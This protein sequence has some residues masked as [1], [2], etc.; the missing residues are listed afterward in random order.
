MAVLTNVSGM[1]I[2][3]KFLWRG[4]FRYINEAY[5]PVVEQDDWD[6]ATVADDLQAQILAST[7]PEE[8]MHVD[9]RFMS[10]TARARGMHPQV[11]QSFTRSLNID[12]V[13][14]GNPTPSWLTFN[15]FQ[16]PDNENRYVISPP[17]TVFKPGRMAF[18]GIV[19][20]DIDGETLTSG[21]GNDYV[22]FAL[23]LSGISEGVV[24][25]DNPGFE[26]VMV[27]RAP[28]APYA[29]RQYANILSLQEGRIGHQD[30]ARK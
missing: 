29:P 3:F 25:A 9:C 8:A 10:F 4:V 16:I 1:E 19:A 30:T 23:I 21:A 7:S 2:Q 11:G 20:E 17:Q 12:G 6:M 14:T 22:S 5:F 24:P 28:T 13:K 15:I 18:P 27:R 26:W